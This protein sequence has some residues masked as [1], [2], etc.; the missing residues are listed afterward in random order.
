MLPERE[1]I[2]GEARK[3]N[4]REDEVSMALTCP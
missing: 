3:K 1:N 2:E 4:W